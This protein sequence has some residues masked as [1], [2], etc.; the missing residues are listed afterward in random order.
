MDIETVVV[1]G[2]EGIED[3]RRSWL[4]ESTKQGSPGISETEEASTGP[5]GSVTDPLHIYYGC[6]LVWLFC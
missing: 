4:T 3:T 5:R 6:L 1:R 2:A